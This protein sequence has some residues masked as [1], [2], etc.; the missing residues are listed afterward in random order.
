LSLRFDHIGVVVEELA[1]G[2]EFLSETL[3]I[4]RWTE[5]I[6]DEALGVWVQFG[7]G[8]DGPCFEL[9][10]PLGEKSP[11]AGAL[12]AGKNILNHVAYLTN[13]LAAEGER[14]R[15]QGCLPTGAAQAAVAY[16]GRRVQFW[17]SPLRFMIELVEAPEHRHV[18]GAAGN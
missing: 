17:I 18:F 4:E 14:L 15:A 6:A 10:A 13:D 5:A 16:G 7:V 1:R 12:R 8:G 11:I 2:R 3:G 9:V